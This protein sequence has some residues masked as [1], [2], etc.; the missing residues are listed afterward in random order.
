MSKLTDEQISAFAK[1]AMD[2]NS[3]I[4]NF[5]ELDIYEFARAIEVAATAPLL[6]RI[7]QLEREL[8]EARKDAERYRCL[9]QKRPVLLL[10]GFF[11]N[12][13]I[14]CTLDEVDAAIDAA[15]KKGQA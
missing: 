10:T 12:G 6:E 11:G 5:V 4:A 1:Q 14:N 2:A 9:K 8:D 15:M 3:P 7:A 13:C